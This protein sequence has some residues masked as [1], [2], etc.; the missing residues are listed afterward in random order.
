[1][2]KLTIGL[3]EAS[4][5][6]NSETAITNYIVQHLFGVYIQ[7]VFVTVQTVA[8]SPRGAT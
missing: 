5:I 8:K 1:L 6:K 4:N 2:K 7:G 3:L